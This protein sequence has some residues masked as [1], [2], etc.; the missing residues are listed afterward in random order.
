MFCTI[1]YLWRNL[2]NMENVYEGLLLFSCNFTKISTP[3][4]EFF[5]FF[6]LYKWYQ[7]AQRDTFRSRN[8]SSFSFILLKRKLSVSSIIESYNDL[9]FDFKIARN[10]PSLLWDFYISKEIERRLHV[11]QTPYVNMVCIEFCICKYRFHC[12]YYSHINIPLFHHRQYIRRQHIVTRS[13]S[14]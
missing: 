3:L 7:I 4:W 11:I 12:Y 9:N 13:I 5:T 1:W 14:S 10:D 6:K 8:F 2:K